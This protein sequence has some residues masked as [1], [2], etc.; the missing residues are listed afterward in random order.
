MNGKAPF[1]PPPI[2]NDPCNVDLFDKFIA[3]FIP[4]DALA[5]LRDTISDQYPSSKYADDTCSAGNQK[6]RVADVIRDAVF[7]C[8]TRLLFD[9]YRGMI[10]TY[11]MEYSVFRDVNAAVHASDVLPTFWN[12]D[13]S[14]KKVFT[15]C[16]S[17]KDSFVVDAVAAYFNTFAP[18]YQSYLTSHAIDG[19][20]NSNKRG[21]AKLSKWRT[22]S[23]SADGD[24]VTN[25]MRANGPGKITFNAGYTDTINTL[26]AC[27]FWNNIA[28][29]IQTESQKNSQMRFD[30]QD[31]FGSE[32]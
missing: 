17:V 21:L 24:K 5:Y 3:D 25:V 32:L 18:A 13:I 31:T 30:D 20:P 27:G 1:I 6:L 16:G 28:A 11:M 4:Q 2:K 14:M 9:A 15:E 29:A 12:K 19:D 7:T 23:T 22:A 26:S 10:P 8:N